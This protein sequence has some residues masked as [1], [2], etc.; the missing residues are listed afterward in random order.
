MSNKWID[1]AISFAMHNENKVDRDLRIADLKAYANEPFY[2]IVGPAK[3]R[4]GP[5]GLIIK[6]GYII[7]QWGDIKRV[8]MDFSATKKLSLYSCR[9]C[10]RCKTN[11]ECK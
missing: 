1:S 7:G 4:G 9:A 8:D 5:A 10:N 2:K 11:Q 6:N 3:Q